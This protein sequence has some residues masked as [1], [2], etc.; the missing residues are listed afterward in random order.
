MSWTKYIYFGS[1]HKNYLYFLLTLLISLLLTNHCATE[2]KKSK[3]FSGR[4]SLRNPLSP[5]DVTIHPDIGNFISQI[6]Y[7]EKEILFSP[8]FSE[9]LQSGPKME[10][11]PFLFPF[12]NRLE[13]WAVPVGEELFPLPTNTPILKDKANLPMHGFLYHRKGWEVE[14]VRNSELNSAYEAT[15]NSKEEDKKIFPFPFEL[16]MELELEENSLTFITLI[17]NTGKVEMPLSVGFHPY[18]WVPIELKPQA[19]ISTN[20][21][22][23]SIAND[24]LLPTG[25]SDLT[26]RIVGNGRADE[27]FLDHSFFD[28]KEKPMASIT[29]P[30]RRIK[31]IL[32]QGYDHIQIFNPKDRDFICLEPMLGPVN[33]FYGGG[34]TNQPVHTLSSGATWKGVWRLEIEAKEE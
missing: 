16:K 7:R 21:L 17:T 32:E 18:F 13:K 10:G 12:A 33:S 28:F 20:A 4:Y 27:H 23:V 3:L 19:V 2:K 15:Y 31:I 24:K 5:L 11:I 6:T 26:T 34:K 14:F 30:D 29:L 9:H 8:Y 25:K 1:T 22:K